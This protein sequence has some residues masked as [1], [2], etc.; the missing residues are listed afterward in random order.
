MGDYSRLGQAH[1]AI[2]DWCRSHGRTPNGTRWEI[3]GH[4]TDDVSKLRTDVYYLLEP[5]S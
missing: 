5:A 3:Y 2:I 4:W 1:S